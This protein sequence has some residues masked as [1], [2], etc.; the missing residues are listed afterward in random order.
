MSLGSNLRLYSRL[1]YYT[2]T[3]PGPRQYRAQWNSFWGSIERTGP[4]GDVLWDNVPE[5]AVA[6]DFAR[7][8]QY[9]HPN[10]PLIDVGCGNGRQTRFLAQ[11]GGRVI[12]ADVSS[13]AIGLATAESRGIGNIEF[14]ALDV[15]KPDQASALHDEIGDANIYIRGVVHAIQKQDRPAVERSLAILLGERGTLYQVELSTEAL[16]YFRQLPGDSPSGLPR[17][18]HRVV[19]FGIRPVGFNLIDRASI[20]PDSRWHLLASGEDVTINTVILSHGEEGHVPANFVI[21]RPRAPR[22]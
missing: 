10:L 13:A 1:I 11:Q 17:L 19:R 3:N 9:M 21:V 5:R 6:D 14:R 18:L 16:T 22:I 2:L 12:G 4:G 20:F 7:L 8:R 15:T